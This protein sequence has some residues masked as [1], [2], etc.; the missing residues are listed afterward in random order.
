MEDNNYRDDFELFLKGSADEFRMIPSRK[1]WYSIYNNIHPARRWPSMAVCLL[2]LTAVLYIGIENN[3]SLSNDARKIAAENFNANLNENK[4]DKNITFL[5]PFS[6]NPNKTKQKNNATLLL[7]SINTF[8]DIEA[9]STPQQ[10]VAVSFSTNIDVENKFSNI[11]TTTNSEAVSGTDNDPANKLS[12]DNKFKVVSRTSFS[13]VDESKSFETNTKIII[14]EKETAFSIQQDPTF[15]KDIAIKA[16]NDNDK[17]LKNLLSNTEK[18]W[19][20]DYA[21]RNKPAINKLKQN[22]SISYYITPS[23][24]YRKFGKRDY[25]KRSPGYANNFA[26][27][28]LTGDR[29]LDDE[30]ALNLELGAAFQYKVSKKMRIKTG[31]QFNYTNYTSNVTSLGHPS[32]VALDVSNSSQMY[33]ASNYSSASGSSMLNKS[34]IQIALPIGADVKIADAGNVEWY[35]GATLQPTYLIKGSGYVLSS[36]GGHYASKPTLLRNLNLNSAIETFISFKPSSRVTM[37]VGPQLRYQLFSSFK[38]KYN[39]SEKLYNIGIKLGIS[40]TF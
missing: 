26:N 2:I 1:I 31:L 7:Q 35:A 24:G 16:K 11:I 38:N 8:E 14:E 25:V 4:S 21:F 19:K 3:N 5:Q 39:Y 17:D 28:G 40:T 29:K 18:S 33:A 13:M 20:E 15:I 32:Q 37:T 22:G 27:T 6:S 36:D 30:A 12:S 23:L 34:T 10:N 9:L